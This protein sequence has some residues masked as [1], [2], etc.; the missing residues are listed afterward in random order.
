MIDVAGDMIRA[1]AALDE[2]QRRL[3]YDCIRTARRPISR[4]EAASA[5][6]ISRKLAAFHLDKLVS[7]GLLR[8]QLSARGVARVGRR[9]KVYELADA[10]ILISIPTRRYEMLAHILTQALLTEEQHGSAKAA[11]ARAARERGLTAGAAV[12]DRIRPGRL[13]AERALTLAEAILA[14]SGFDPGRN[15]PRGLR[16][17]NCPFHPLAGSAPELICEINLAFVTG[18][19]AGLQADTVEAVLAP[20]ARECCVELRRRV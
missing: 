5:V 2:P 8:S 11:A 13:G 14:A 17:R 16:L 10:D 9:P 20:A 6:G 19:L 15:D 1:V 7:A 12:R 18:I 3:L 4:D